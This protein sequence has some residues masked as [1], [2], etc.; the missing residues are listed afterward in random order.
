M[1]LRPPS[2]KQFFTLALCGLILHSAG[3]AQAFEKP[4]WLARPLKLKPAKPSLPQ[5]SLNQAI[6]AG[7]LKQV[8][9]LLAKKRELNVADADG[10]TPLHT[11]SL[12]GNNDIVKAL[13]EKGVAVDASNPYGRTPL[14]NASQ[15]GHVDVVKTLIAHGANVNAVD[16]YLLD[17]TP[18][19]YACKNGYFEIAKDLLQHGAKLNVV[20]R[21]RR[22]T[23]LHLA[24]AFG[25]IDIV[26]VL[27]LNGANIN[28][29]DKD[30]K[31]PLAWAMERQQAAV[32]KLLKRSGGKL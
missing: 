28:A 9:R 16:A 29:R 1:K 10:A 20:E 26:Y 13:L 14:I 24:S 4:A 30:S 8:K 27:L 18:L 21:E 2:F 3:M 5:N 25:Y 17:D 31:T 11:A 19:L 23:P 22:L 15:N 7:D 6:Q 12:L 32:V